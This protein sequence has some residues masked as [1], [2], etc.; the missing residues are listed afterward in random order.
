MTYTLPPAP[1]NNGD[2]A[3]DGVALDRAGVPVLDADD[4]TKSYPGEPPVQALRGVN[5]TICRGSWWVSS[6]RRGRARPPCC[7]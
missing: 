7:S 3:G 4:V 5:L 2:A 1:D 6:A